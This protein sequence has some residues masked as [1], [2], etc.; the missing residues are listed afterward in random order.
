MREMAK[1]MT[2]AIDEAWETRDMTLPLKDK[3]DLLILASIVEKETGIAE[4]MPI[5][6]SVFVNR[7]KKGMKLQADPTVIYGASNYQ[8]DLTSA[9][10]REPHAYNTYVNFGLPPG[11]IA[12]PGKLA[13]QASARPAKTDYLFF[14]ADG[15]GGHLFART[16][17]EHQANVRQFL[18]LLRSGKAKPAV[19]IEPAAGEGEEKL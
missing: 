6:A 5:V 8:G 18:A 16:Y 10:M 4:E 1:A 13:I 7:L 17:K 14:V 3:K 12:N 19:V 15:K 9:H 2:K 11:P